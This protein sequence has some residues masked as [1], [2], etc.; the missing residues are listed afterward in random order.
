MMRAIVELITLNKKV[1]R[2]VSRRLS[3]NVRTRR[4]VADQFDSQISNVREIPRHS[5]ENEQIR[6][7]LE[8]QR[9]QI[10]VDCQAEFRKHEFQANYDRRSIQKL[11]EMIESQRG[12]TSTRSTTSSCKLLAQNRDLR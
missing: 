10:L 12:A 8:R 2:P 1:C 7:L 5:S 6:I 4:L 11:N 3:V 9:E